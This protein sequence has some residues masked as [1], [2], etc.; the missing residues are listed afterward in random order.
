MHNISLGALNSVTNKYTLPTL[1]LKTDK[2]KCVECRKNVILKKGQIK[3]AHFAHYAQSNVCNYYDRPNEAQI[4]KDAKLLMVKLLTDKVL[5]Q[6]CW[7]CD[8]CI[9]YPESFPEIENSYRYYG[10]FYYNQ[11]FP[12]LD[13]PSIEYKDGDEV[14]TEFRDKNNKWVADVALVNNGEVR[15]IFEIKNTHATIT[16]C[17]PEPWYEVKADNF[18]NKVNEIMGR[19]G[20]EKYEKDHIINI[21]C[22]RKIQFRRCYGSFCSRET[23]VKYICINSNILINGCIICENETT[24]NVGPVRIC[25][26]CLNKDIHT[27]RIRKAYSYDDFHE[28]NKMLETHG[29]CNEKGQCLYPGF[30]KPCFN[31]CKLVTCKGKQ[32]CGKYPQNYLDSFSGVCKLCYDRDCESK[33]EK[34]IAYFKAVQIE[35]EC[36]RKFRAEEM[37]ER[38]IIEIDIA[39]RKEELE[40]AK[41]ARGG[42]CNCNIAFSDLCSCENP[43][44]ILNTIC[45]NCEGRACRCTKRR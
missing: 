32:N 9:K 44:I 38:K 28:K 40:N 43:N 24:D 5:L 2:Y 1:A 34:D 36:F 23:W 17:R 19:T 10:P 11:P 4:H 26:D 7:D 30:N 15:Y 31:G 22:I 8:Y 33:L 16:N 39:K 21:E 37:K 35:D 25:Y 18:I 12:D 13:T 42:V 45:L 3:R 6:F 14:I 27:Q 20:E 29:F 41:K